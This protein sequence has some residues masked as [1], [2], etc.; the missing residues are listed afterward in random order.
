MQRQVSTYDQ[1]YSYVQTKAK[2]LACDHRILWTRFN[3]G[4]LA[5][6]QMK[7]NTNANKKK[8]RVK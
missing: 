2:L 4:I 3:K 1:K 7:R 8:K 5:Q 6:K